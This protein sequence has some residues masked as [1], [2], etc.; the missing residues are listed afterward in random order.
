MCARPYVPM[1]G[2]PAPAFRAMHLRRGDRCREP[3]MACGD[4][5][6]PRCGDM[7]QVW[8]ARVR[9]CPTKVRGPGRKP[10][11]SSYTLTR[12]YL[13]DQ[14]VIGRPHPPH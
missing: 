12:L 11:A 14:G 10:G 1:Y 6:G 5:H 9:T 7:S 8:P 3:A 4:M 13:P 2:D